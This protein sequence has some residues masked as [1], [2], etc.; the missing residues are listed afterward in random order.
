MGSWQRTLFALDGAQLN[1]QE[2]LNAIDRVL[3]DGA[4]DTRTRRILET[5]CEALRAET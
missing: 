2:A 3:R 5:A 1:I 4:V